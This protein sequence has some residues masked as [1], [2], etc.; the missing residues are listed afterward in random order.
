MAIQ[1]AR[2]YSFR[3]SNLTATQLVKLVENWG[4]KPNII[5]S[6]E[7]QGGGI[8]TVVIRIERSTNAQTTSELEEEI[9]TS[10]VEA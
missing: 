2:L 10:L 4:K 5:D 6:L 9:S 3:L 1:R 8:Y 7:P